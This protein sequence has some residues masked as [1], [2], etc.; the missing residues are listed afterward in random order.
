MFYNVFSLKQLIFLDLYYPIVQAVILNQQV[1]II[2]IMTKIPMF[3][4]ALFREIIKHTI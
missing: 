1:D 3:I 2:M 4:F